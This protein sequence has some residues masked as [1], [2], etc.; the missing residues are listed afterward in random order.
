MDVEL[1]GSVHALYGNVPRIMAEVERFSPDF[2]G[3]ELTKPD[4]PTGSRDVDAVSGRYRD[5]LVCLD[6]PPEVTV[7]RY[8][9]DTPPR[10]FLKECLVKFMWLP[11]NQASI[12]MNNYLPWLYRS[13]FG[14]SFFSFGWSENDTRYYIHERDEYMAGKF[15]EFLRGR[16]NQ[17]YKDRYVILTGRRHVAGITCILE[18]YASTKGIGSYYAGGKVTD[19]F[20]LRELEEPYTV[21]HHTA[22]NNFVFNRLIESMVST[23]FLPVY[24]LALFAIVI[25]T[26]VLV[27]LA[28]ATITG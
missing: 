23:L 16:E 21:E 12:H 10:N 9:C 20:R 4:R 13:L 14:D 3:V 5:R 19:V 18:A 17:G 15:L 24:M 28:L 26:A 1:L 25:S 2:I 6:R 11:L 27:I 8:M 7:S 22:E